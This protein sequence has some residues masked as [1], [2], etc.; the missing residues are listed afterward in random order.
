MSKERRLSIRSGRVMYNKLSITNECL[1]NSAPF[2]FVIAK[3]ILPLILEM[4]D[5]RL[6]RVLN[7]G[8][9]TINPG[10]G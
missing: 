8:I 7:H 3:C 5:I 9:T 6:A 10:W 1:R 4:E 2:S